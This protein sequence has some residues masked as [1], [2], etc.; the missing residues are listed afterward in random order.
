M[1]SYILPKNYNFS[2][3][4]IIAINNQTQMISLKSILN[5]NRVLL[6]F[7]HMYMSTKLIKHEINIV[8]LVY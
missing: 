4:V 7:K 1:I 3:A 6:S 5:K 8:L 2:S